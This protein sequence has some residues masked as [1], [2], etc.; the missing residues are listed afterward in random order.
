MI[1]AISERE[2]RGLYAAAVQQTR[3]GRLGGVQVFASPPRD[4]RVRR[5][6]RKLCDALV[7]LALEEGYEAVTV[8]ALTGR[9]GV[10][11]ATFFRHFRNKD[12]LLRVLLEETLGDLMAQLGPRATRANPVGV[13]AP[14]FEHALAHAARYRVLLAAG[15]AAGAIDLCAQLCRRTL[16]VN[17]V[18]KPGSA[19]PFEVAVQH[20]VRSFIWLLSW[21]LSERPAYT[22][23]QM[24]RIVEQLIYAPTY[25]VALLR[26]P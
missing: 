7:E 17:F 18:P 25:E 14:I 6:Y 22:P 13:S 11:Y 16:A 15:E 8:R 5:T 24:G 19:V 20:L 26:R 2:R 10:G 12:A 9:A 4:L 1:Q 23:E 3:R 21:Y